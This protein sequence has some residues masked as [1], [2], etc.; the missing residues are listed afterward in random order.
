MGQSGIECGKI[1]SWQT[2]RTVSFRLKFIKYLNRIFNWPKQ[3]FTW[4]F[5]NFLTVSY[6]MIFLQQWG[7]KLIIENVQL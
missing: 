7:T 2:G 6:D 1:I 5:I 4:P 3:I